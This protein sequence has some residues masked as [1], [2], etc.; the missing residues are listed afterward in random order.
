MKLSNEQQGLLLVILLI[1]LL[2]VGLNI[3]LY[4]INHFTS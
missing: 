4:L 3:A 2:I 1:S